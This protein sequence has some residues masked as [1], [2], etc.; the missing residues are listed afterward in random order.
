[1]FQTVRVILKS[2]SPS[3]ICEHNTSNSG[4]SG[5]LMIDLQ[6]IYGFRNPTRSIASVSIF[7]LSIM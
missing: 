5:H 2:P 3:T 1:M 7:I 4:Q 6:Q